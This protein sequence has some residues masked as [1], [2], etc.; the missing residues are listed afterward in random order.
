MFNYIQNQNSILTDEVKSTIAEEVASEVRL[1]FAIEMMR[2]PTSDQRAAI[3]AEITRATSVALRRRALGIRFEDELQLADEI[4]SRLIGLGFLDKLLPPTRTDLSEITMD[5]FGTI[6]LKPKG[7]REFEPLLDLRPSVVEV[8]TVF[9]A[10]FGQQLKAFSEANPS[11][12]ATLPRTKD[13]PG[14]GRIKY[15]HPVISQGAG[16]PSVNIRLF[17]P[18]PV[19]PEFLLERQMLDECTLDLLAEL[20]RRGARGLVCGGTS[21]GK[22]TLLSMLCNFLPIK[23]RIVTI[24]DPQEIWIDNPHTVTLQARPS[25]AGSE[26]RSYLLRDG[27]DDAMRMT[28]D[29]LVVGEVR[30]GH[31]AQGLFRA[32]MSDHPGMSTFHAESPALAVERLALLLESDTG[33][34]DAAARRMFTAAV[35]WLLQI[36][37]DGAGQ[38]RVFELVEVEEQLNHGNVAFNPLVKF[39]GAQWSQLSSPNRARGFAASV[40]NQWRDVLALDESERQRLQPIIERRR[41]AYMAKE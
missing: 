15:I 4:G 28:P 23:S 26:L 29:Y 18:L 31:A 36:G 39:D 8:D 40:P 3:K 32:M 2:A 25:N 27:V 20:V 35:D 7:Q 12:N 13:N 16:Y 14:G 38:R 5:S 30:D 37:F 1:K 17:E 6:W 9:S 24:E 10:L 11:V 34:R 21:S 22:T 41:L 19:K 33:T